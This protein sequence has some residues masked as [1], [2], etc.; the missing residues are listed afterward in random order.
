MRKKKWNIPGNILCRWMIRHET[1]D[2]FMF[3]QSKEE[4]KPL[5]CVFILAAIDFR[6]CCLYLLLSD[7]CCL[8]LLCCLF[9]FVLYLCCLLLY[10]QYFVVCLL[11]IFI[12]AVLCFR[13][14]CCIF[15]MIYILLGFHDLFCILFLWFKLHCVVII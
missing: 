5:I 15:F 13:D 9:L 2:L 12:C 6:L 10:V 8:F 4:K 11:P 14:V 1:V 3:L 7:V